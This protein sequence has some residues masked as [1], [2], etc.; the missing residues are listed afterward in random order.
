MN[1]TQEKLIEKIQQSNLEKADQD[2]LI[3]ILRKQGVDYSKFISKFLS[4]IGLGHKAVTVFKLFDID[5][6]ELIDKF[7]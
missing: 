2:V 1:F 5:I 3:E 7:L 4:I 6:E